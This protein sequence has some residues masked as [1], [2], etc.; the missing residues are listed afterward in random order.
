MKW[1]LLIRHSRAY[2]HKH[3]HFYVFGFELRTDAELTIFLAATFT[4]YW[5]HIKEGW[6]RRHEANVLFLFYEGTVSDWKATIRKV[7]NFLEVTLN[8]E[9]VCQLENHFKFERFKKNKSVNHENKFEMNWFKEGEGSFI[10]RGKVGGWRD[11]F[12]AEEAKKA[13]EWLKENQKA[14]GIEFK[15]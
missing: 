10:R 8:D 7:A 1:S 13:E 15:F 11:Y 3:L 2:K 9:Q 14:I 6:E 5:S 12:D 4:P